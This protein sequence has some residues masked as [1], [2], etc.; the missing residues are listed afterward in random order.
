MR[1]QVKERSHPGRHPPPGGGE[2]A[3]PR[4]HA[5]MLM[6]SHSLTYTEA[7]RRITALSSIMNS[8]LPSSARRVLMSLVQVGHSSPTGQGTE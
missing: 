3:Q 4:M 5:T 6:K 2:A 7:G 1:R 8:R